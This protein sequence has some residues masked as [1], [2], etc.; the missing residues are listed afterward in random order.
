MSDES[1]ILQARAGHAA[2]WEQLVR[3]NQEVVFRLA[4]LLLR[5]A[6]EADDVAQETFIRAHGALTGFDTAR[7]LR[8]WLLRI[9][10]NLARNRRRSLRRSLAAL[11][12]AFAL[13]PHATQLDESAGWERQTLWAAV[14]RLGSADQEV[15]YLRYFLDLSEADTARAL[16]VRQ[17]TVKSRTSRALAR[18]RSL[19][20]REFPSLRTEREL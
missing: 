5:D 13:A 17:G 9:S 2:A 7:P 10:A 19:I 1:L 11:Q 6:D 3:A 8:P 16:A 18:L 4:Y 15:L 12:R 14:G 20:D